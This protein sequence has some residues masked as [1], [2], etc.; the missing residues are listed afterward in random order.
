M[1]RNHYQEVCTMR[2]VEMHRKDGTTDLVPVRRYNRQAPTVSH[3]SNPPAR[4]R[5]EGINLRDM[6]RSSRRMALLRRSGKRSIPVVPIADSAP[7]RSTSFYLSIPLPRLSHAARETVRILRS[8]SMKLTIHPAREQARHR[9]ETPEQIAERMNTL[10]SNPWAGIVKAT[11]T[12]VAPRGIVGNGIKVGLASRVTTRDAGKGHELHDP[13]LLRGLATVGVATHPLA[14]AEIYDA[15]I[16]ACRRRPAL[17]TVRVITGDVSVIK[18]VSDYVAIKT[19]RR[20][21][22]KQ[23]RQAVITQA[24]RDAGLMATM[25]TIHSDATA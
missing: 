11:E 2:F 18:P 7:I 12:R 17:S 19:E 24:Q 23:A 14:T 21:A 9:R 5:F 15:A 4:W 6:Q 22:R 13:F 25:G 8:D 3:V 20:N 10:A 16:A 1:P